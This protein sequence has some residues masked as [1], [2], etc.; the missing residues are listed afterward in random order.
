L[1][2]GIVFGFCG[3]GF[4]AGPGTIVPGEGMTVFGGK[5][6]CVLAL[7]TGPFENVLPFE[8]TGLL[9]GLPLGYVIVGVPQ[10]EQPVGAETDPCA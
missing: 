9:I 5:L 10:E 2:R 3:N 8:I 4:V 7:G 1:F 6:G